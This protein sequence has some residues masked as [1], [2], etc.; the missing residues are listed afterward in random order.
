[1]VA[2]ATRKFPSKL[3]IDSKKSL[4]ALFIYFLK[5]SFLFDK[6]LKNSLR[7]LK[8]NLIAR[9]ISREQFTTTR[10]FHSLM[11]SY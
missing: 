10:H 1:M 7:I 8:Y 6:L 9:G 4:A 3:L 5:L 11:E 2:D